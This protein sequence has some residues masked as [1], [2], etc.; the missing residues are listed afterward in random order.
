MI[1]PYED[2]DFDAFR[3]MFG[4]YFANDFQMPLSE[5]DL[6]KVCT[7]IA[8]DLRVVPQLFLDLAVVDGAPVGFIAYQ[9]DSPASDWC[10]REGWGMVRELYVVPA[11]RRQGHGR[12]LAAHAADVLTALGVPGLYLTGDDAAEAFWTALGY[13]PTAQICARNDCRIYVRETIRA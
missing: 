13:R 7:D 1:R 5:A 3:T 10:E 2:S 11:R 4:D 12:A 8:R 6:T 9:V